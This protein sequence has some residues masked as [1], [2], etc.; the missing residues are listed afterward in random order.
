MVEHEQLV[1]AEDE[2]TGELM[3]CIQVKIKKN[4]GSSGLPGFGQEE[5]EDAKVGEFTCLAVKSDTITTVSNANT[6]AVVVQSSRSS[7]A[8]RCGRGIGAALVRA[9]EAHCRQE[10]CGRMQLGI[11]CPAEGP[12]PEYKQ[13]L[14]TYYQS[15]GYTYQSTL[16]LD[17]E[18]DDEGNVLVDQ[19]HDMY[20]PLHQLVQCN[21]ILYDKVL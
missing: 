5:N 15:L 3:G 12:E 11:M 1:L 8:N 4:S 21:A 17:F 18:T 20:E 9:A 10:G 2:D 7:E 13:W 14:Q 19:L 6:Q 16:T